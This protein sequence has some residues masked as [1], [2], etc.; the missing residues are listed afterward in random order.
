MTVPQSLNNFLRGQVQFV[1]ARGFEIE[2]IAS[3]GEWLQKFADRDHVEVHAVEMPRAISPL[4]DMKAIAQLYKVLRQIRPD[5][6]QS[7][8]SKAG[9]LGTIAAW[10]AR[11]P[12]R[13]YHIR[14]M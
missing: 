2:A 7:G 11:S 10:L 13:I 6:V 5:I 14:G 3:P 8:T 1:E 9:L 4:G 12:V